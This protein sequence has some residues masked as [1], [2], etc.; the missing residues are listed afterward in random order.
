[1]VSVRI[2]DFPIEENQVFASLIQLSQDID[3]RLYSKLNDLSMLFGSFYVKVRV[4]SESQV[5]VS[6]SVDSKET[7]LI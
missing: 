4:R 6:M 5:V 7:D 2:N 1:M 3:V